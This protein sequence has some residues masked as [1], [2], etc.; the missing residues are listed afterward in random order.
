MKKILLMNL[1]GYES[2]M[3]ECLTLAKQHA[4]L[5]YSMTGD[6]LVLVEHQHL[7][8]VNV[9]SLTRSELQIWSDM[10]NEQISQLEHARE[11]IVILAA[12]VKYRGFIP[13]GT[14]IGQGFRIGA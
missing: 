13:L 9:L 6:G 2:R 14:Q 4:D 5:I 7:V 11:D 8:P 12:G 10:M 1:G 3:D